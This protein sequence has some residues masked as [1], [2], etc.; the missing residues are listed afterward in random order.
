MKHILIGAAFVL[1]P[2]AFAG[3]P[4]TQATKE[5]QAQVLASHLLTIQKI[6]IWQSSILL[7]RPSHHQ[8]R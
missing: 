6:S 8:K 5:A 4:A 7:A 2:V 1:A 3:K